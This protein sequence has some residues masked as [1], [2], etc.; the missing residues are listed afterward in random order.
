MGSYVRAHV[1]TFA[2]AYEEGA[3][4]EGGVIRTGGNHPNFSFNFATNLRLIINGF[5][6]PFR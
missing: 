6:M 3:G 2:R 4:V 1:R 5:S